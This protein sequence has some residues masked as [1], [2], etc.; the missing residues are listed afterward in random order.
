MNAPPTFPPNPT[1]GQWFWNWVWNGS[2]WVQAGGSGGLRIINQIFFAGPASTYM[3]SPGLTTVVVQCQGAGGGGGGAVATFT[4]GAT[5]G[6]I[7]GGGGGAA[8]VHS[9]K[10]LPAA[11]VLG[12]VIV[13]VGTAG[14]GGVGAADGAQGG[15]TSFGALCI[16]PGG[17]GGGANT[18]NGP[19]TPTAQWGHG[20]GRLVFGDPS[21]VGDFGVAGCAGQAGGTVFL[22]PGIAGVLVWGGAGGSSFWGAAGQQTVA[23]AVDQ[24]TPTSYGEVGAGGSGG[25]TGLNTAPGTGNRG[26]NGICICTEY[27]WNDVGDACC[28]PVCGSGQARVQIGSGGW[29]PYDGQG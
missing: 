6:F 14:A 7:T 10:T 22:N 2:A 17:F 26:G 19:G 11:L 27:C 12:G 24:V 16:A 4:G 5:P 18:Y 28:V 29:N 20:G 25:A 1:V 23:N 3:P 13:N 9:V 21:I 15:A 8:G